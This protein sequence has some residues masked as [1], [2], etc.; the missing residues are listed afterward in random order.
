MPQDVPPPDDSSWTKQA[1]DAYLNAAHD[2][3]QRKYSN[4][5]PDTSSEVMNAAKRLVE[6]IYPA[7]AAIEPAHRFHE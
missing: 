7:L 1:A 5:D 4:G 3:A 6:C 2:A